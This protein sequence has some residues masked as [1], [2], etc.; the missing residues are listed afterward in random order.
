MTVYI[1]DLNFLKIT[2][3]GIFCMSKTCSHIC[4]FLKAPTVWLIMLTNNTFL[5]SHNAAL[6]MS[7]TNKHVLSMQQH[8]KQNFHC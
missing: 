6:S 7:T 8:Q 2:T 3:S 5:Y 4:N 1:K